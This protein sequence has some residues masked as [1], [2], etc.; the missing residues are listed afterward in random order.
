MNFFDSDAC[1]KS[2][3]LAE[4]RETFGFVQWTSAMGRATRV[5]PRAARLYVARH[6]PQ[7]SSR[8]AVL[9]CGAIGTERER[10]HRAIVELARSCADAGFTAYRFDYAGIGESG[11]RFDEQCFSTW[12]D[13]IA[14]LVQRIAQAHAVDRVVDQAADHVAHRAHSDVDYPITLWGVRAGALLVSRCFAQGV[15]DAAFLCAPQ[16]G[17]AMLIDI[18]RRSVIAGMVA[19][20]SDRA[21]SASPEG[22]APRR[23]S[24]VLEGG[25]SA[26][27]DGYRWTPQLWHDAAMHTIATPH[28]EET[29]PWRRV[30]LRPPNA[31]GRV[32]PRAAV[33]GIIEGDRFWD[34]GPLLVAR[35][36]ALADATIAFLAQV[37]ADHLALSP[38]SSRASTRAQAMTRLWPIKHEAADLV[39][40]AVFTVEVGAHKLVGTS[41]RVRS[42]IGAQ[43][44]RGLLL[45]NAGPA[46]RAGN[47][48]LSVRMCDEV[49]QLGLPCFRVDFA[50][51]GDASGDSWRMITQYARAAHEGANDTQLEAVIDHL[52]AQHNL[53]ALYVGGLCAGATCAIRAAEFRSARLAGLLLIEP[54]LRRASQADAVVSVDATNATSRNARSVLE[55]LRD[56]DRVMARVATWIERRH[57]LAPL[58]R[59]LRSWLTQRSERQLP[60]DVARPI[61]HALNT[62]LTRDIPTLAVVGESGDMDLYLGRI[63]QAL[64][65]ARTPMYQVARLPGANHLLTSN[66]AIETGVMTALEWI[67]AQEASMLD[68]ATVDAR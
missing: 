35:T 34:A 50:G 7:T 15:G 53:D 40:R 19:S 6:A 8:G 64:K 30:E 11:G 3:V 13:Q 55:R 9:L 48:D 62:A 24:E 16:D 63:A 65:F 17:R 54:A 47:S 4:S 33:E 22:A 41:H 49:A 51:L 42:N 38:H 29:R 68:G 31:N 59:P 12:S 36:T 10:G 18:A 39:E 58:A 60:A 21:T 61:V 46:P 43:A 5:A 2:I 56:P 32:D 25:E 44:R 14:T 1:E 45:L 26:N 27:I 20:A 52:C 23:I 57:P 28:E 66:G 67:R 37:S